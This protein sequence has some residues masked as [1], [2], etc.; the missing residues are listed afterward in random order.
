MPS[1]STP[2]CTPDDG[3]VGEAR[4]RAASDRE[5]A[6]RLL[7]VPETVRAEIARE[8][9]AV[10]LGRPPGGGGSCM[11]R[12][13][14]A[15]AVLRHRLG[16]DVPAVVGGL[17]YRYGPDLGDVLAFAG[18]DGRCALQLEPPSFLGHF[19]AGTAD[20]VIDFSPQD[21]P[22]LVGLPIE[23]PAYVWERPGER[24]T[25]PPALGQEVPAGRALYLPSPG[26]PPL[27]RT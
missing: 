26:L 4:R 15:R 2:R 3:A 23:V 25:L 7:V 16:L 22:A 8:V 5:L 21:W 10:D 17:T 6:A 19:W 18:D 1:V 20:V 11:F 12:A 24:V 9:Q 14:A 13:C 27:I